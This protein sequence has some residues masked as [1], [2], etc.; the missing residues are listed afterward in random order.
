M[1]SRA[2]SC[3]R[4]VDHA[5]SIA[6]IGPAL[7]PESG[8]SILFKS[9]LDH[10]RACGVTV[11][12]IPIPRG[13]RNILTKPLKFLAVLAKT[14]Q[15][16]WR[17]DVISAH[18]PTPQLSNVALAALIVAK[19]YRRPF[20][21]RKFGGMDPSALR[22]H[23]RFF[24]EQ[25]LKRSSVS[26]VEARK[27][28]DDISKQISTMI[29]WYPNYRCKPEHQPERCWRGGRFVYVG[30]VRQ[31]KGIG[32]IIEAAT[33][34]SEGC[35]VDIYGPCEKEV[36]QELLGKSTSIRYRGII[37]NRDMQSVLSEYDALLL[38][39]YWE[40][41]GYPGVVIEAFQAGLP[42][43]A[44]QWKFIPEIVDETCGILVQ[45][46]DAEGLVS[47]MRRLVNDRELGQHLRTG[48]LSRGDEFSSD[49]WG[50]LFVHA[51]R[52]AGES[53]GNTTEMHRRIKGLYAD[54]RSL[55]APV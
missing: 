11:H 1:G 54:H 14:I 17:V 10:M 22:P 43:I 40:G 44:T 53:L 28:C 51:C 33:H 37:K 42:V 35:S 36:T 48:A 41:E 26:F 4:N 30:R 38:P 13:G 52:I 23:A 15:L 5:L 18:V 31:E 16:A 6:M 39:T 45:P 29:F 7:H 21:L 32:E 20:V 2:T 9:L 19:M 27:Q 25:V 34:L 46:R 24:A 50:D 3:H 8:T 55:L 12:T 49:R 47:A